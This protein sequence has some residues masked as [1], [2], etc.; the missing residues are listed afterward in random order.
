[1]REMKLG[2]SKETSEK[3]T[4]VLIVKKGHRVK[5][6]PLVWARGCWERQDRIEICVVQS[7]LEEREKETDAEETR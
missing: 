6:Q 2:Q 5:R 3:K 4:G 7:K 1:M